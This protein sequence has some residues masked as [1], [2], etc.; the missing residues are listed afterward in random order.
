MLPLDGS[1]STFRAGHK[2]ITA[3]F[4]LLPNH[5]RS[6]ADSTHYSFLD[7]NRYL[8]YGRLWYWASTIV[9]QPLALSSELLWAAIGNALLRSRNISKPGRLHFVFFFRS[10]YVRYS[11][12][13]HYISVTKEKNTLPLP[14]SLFPACCS[15]VWIT[16]KTVQLNLLWTRKR[17]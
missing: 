7:F 11:F 5:L 16:E 1:Q 4:Y 6:S 13:H 12:S 3:G 14:S 9:T 10:N 8:F 2:L 17:N 15:I